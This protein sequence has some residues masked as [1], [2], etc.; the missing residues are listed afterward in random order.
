MLYGT[1]IYGADP[2]VL[3][4]KAQA[5]EKLGFES[6][7]R[8][9]HLLLPA[10]IRES[11]PHA[12]GGRPPFSP[13]AP[14]LDV[15]TVL[16]FLAQATSSI[17]LA[18]G[19]LVLPLREPVA[20]ARAVGTLDVLSRGRAMLGVGAGW[21]EE[22]FG[23]CGQDFATRN[24]RL[25]EAIALLRALWADAEIHHDGPA[26]PITSARFEP[27]PS[28]L[29]G[30]PIVGGGESPRALRRAALKCDGWYGH[31]G[32]AETAAE[33]V[34]HL[35]ELR[36]SRG[37]AAPFEITV[38]VAPDATHDEIARL[39]DAGVDRV[40]AEIGSFE[41]PVGQA[42]LEAMARFADRHIGVPA[43]RHHDQEPVA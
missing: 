9:D 6:L 21:L 28:Q 43:P 4:R 17:R 12:A 23:F 15:L 29:G 30:P 20:V 18:T 37:L 35:R 36:R 10:A 25:D 33:R 39:A 8:G 13:D 2:D 27:K 38:R 5:A 26:Y 24:D 32:D 11:Y 14:V 42:D 34:E 7:W 16:A 19:V 3:I 40:V 22:E 1:R 41:E 31:L